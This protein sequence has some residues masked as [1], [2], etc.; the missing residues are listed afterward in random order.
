MELSGPGVQYIAD[1]QLYNS[2]ITA[3]AI[4]MIFFMV[5]PALIG[6]FGNFLLPLLV[7]GPDMAFPRLNNISFWLLIPSLLLL[8]F[9]AVIE[10]GAGTG[11]TLYPPL[12][13]I[14]SHSGPSV[15]LAIFALHLSGVSSLLGAINFITTIVNMRTPGIKL[16]KLALFGWAVVITAVLL[17]LSLPVLAGGI[18][19]VLTDRNFNTSFFETAGG[20]DPILFQ[21]LFLTKQVYTILFIILSSLTLFT[22]S[23]LYTV[24]CKGAK[25][26]NFESFYKEYSNLYPNNKLPNSKFLEWFI[27]FTEGEGSFTVAKRG[28]LAFVITQS[29][30]DIECLNFIKDNLGFGKVIKQSIKN[31]THRFVVQDIKNLIILCNL[32][33]GNMVFPTRNAKFM[34][35]IS[36]VNEKLLKKNMD[37]ISIIDNLVL[38]SLNDAWLSGISD[39]EASFTCSILSEPNTGYRF[40]Y[41]LTQKWDSNKPTLEFINKL[42]GSKIGAVYTHPESKNNFNIWELRINGVKNCEKIFEYFDKFT[43]NTKKR[44]SYIKWKEVHYKLKTGEHL[45]PEKR[46]EI[47]DLCK[48]INK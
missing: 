11:W 13:G 16:H 12:S 2:I 37:K 19:M 6:G 3:H 8:V 23:R 45:I 20:G 4:L 32:F 10:G 1:N 40:R 18:T 15:D 42:F 33:N 29:T 30:M 39:G 22:S 26:F 35:F 31:N 5:M 25:S 41:I 48:K 24:D 27:G 14:Q 38:P 34:I 28:D 46:L 17:L 43:L 7:G 21:H 9:S 36:A 47:K 44:L